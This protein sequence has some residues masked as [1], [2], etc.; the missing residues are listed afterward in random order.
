MNQQAE[1]RTYEVSTLG[2]FLWKTA[3]YMRFGY[4]RYAL[5]IIPAGK[6]S[7]AIASKLIL[8]YDISYNRDIRKQRRKQGRAN[9][10]LLCFNQSVLLLA[11]EKGE[12]PEFDKI[13]S[14]NFSEQPLQFSGYSIGIKQRK[15]YIQMTNRRYRAIKKQLTWMA[16]YECDRVTRYVKEIS[17]FS[18]QG[19]SDQRWK[20]INEVNRKR[21]RAGLPLIKWQDIKPY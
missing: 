21:K 14:L 11:E 12:H 7:N 15:P 9:M 2:Q 17:P 13:D 19:V 1:K 20:L 5:R 3:L 8:H 10:V 18:F 4:V 6:D 16:L